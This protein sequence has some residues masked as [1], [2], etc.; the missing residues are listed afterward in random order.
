MRPASLDLKSKNLEGLINIDLASLEP[1]VTKGMDITPYIDIPLRIDIPCNSQ[2][3]E[4]II[5]IVTAASLKTAN[6]AAR[7]GIVRNTIAS[8]RDHSNLD[9]SVFSTQSLKRP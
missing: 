1:P 3:V 9:R 5:P 7:D 6:R 4:A 8:R 2:A